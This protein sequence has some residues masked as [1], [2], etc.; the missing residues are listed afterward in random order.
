MTLRR[1]V[2]QSGVAVL[3]ALIA[4]TL[5]STADAKLQVP[6]AEKATKTLSKNICAHITS[7]ND[8]NIGTCVNAAAGPCVSMSANQ[9][10]CEMSQT[11]VYQDGKEIVCATPMEWSVRKSSHVLHGH[12][13]VGT[14][15]KMLKPATPPPP[16]SPPTPP[17]GG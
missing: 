3:S 16:T 2:V 7:L 10:V 11:M 15:C 9:V 13:L 4:L 14:S 17:P 5:V 1:W 12:P 8:P 6:R